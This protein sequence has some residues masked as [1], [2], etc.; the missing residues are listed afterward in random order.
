MGELS[1]HIVS[2][3]DVESR[4]FCSCLMRG[5]KYEKTRERLLI[6][7]NARSSPVAKVEIF[8]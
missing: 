5:S 6:L 8:L 2:D 4:R 3:D 7:M 1:E